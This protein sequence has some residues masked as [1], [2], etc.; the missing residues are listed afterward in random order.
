MMTPKE[1]LYVRLQ[2]RPVDKIPNVNIVMGLA[3]KVAGCSY[4]E[5]VQNYRK[6]VDGNLLCVERYGI[7]AVSAISDPMREASA[8]G[9]AVEFPENGVPFSPVPLLSNPV[10]TSILQQADPLDCPR[11]VDRIQAVELLH[12][13]VGDQ[14]PVIGWVEG[15]LAELADLRGVNDL[16]VDLADGADY[17]AEAMEMVYT[18]QCS[19]AKAQVNAGADFI[20]VGN[21]VASLVGPALYEVHAMAYDRRIV[22]YI[23]GL[24]AKVKFHICGNIRPILE[25]LKQVAPD[26]L[27]IDW[28]V[29]F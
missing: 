7:D 26:I 10:D 29:D 9:A 18:V 21:A 27:D 1:R 3:A 6:L 24:G 19:F 23:H 25:H 5:F 16:M 2:G 12:Q 22:E 17:L 20:G 15:V 8:F 14:Y 28:M 11:T 4:R 13:K